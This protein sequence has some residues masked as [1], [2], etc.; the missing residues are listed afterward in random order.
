MPE[1]DRD[2]PRR[3]PGH[4]CVAAGVC[5]GQLAWYSILGEGEPNMVEIS[6]AV[7]GQYQVEVEGVTATEYALNVTLAASCARSSAAPA[8]PIQDKTPRSS[9][10]VNTASEPAGVVALPEQTLSA[11]RIYLPA[12]AR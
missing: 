5:S 8:A 7:T 6:V 3:C 11:S 1:R 4:L 9:P 2:V 12:I 10:L